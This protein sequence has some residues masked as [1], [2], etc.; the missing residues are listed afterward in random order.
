MS[1]LNLDAIA[2]IASSMSANLGVI[3]WRNYSAS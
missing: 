1:K 3:E 2:V